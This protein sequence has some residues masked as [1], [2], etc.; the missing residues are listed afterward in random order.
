[1]AT[2][3]TFWSALR[4]LVAAPVP[5]PPQPIRPTRIRSLPAACTPGAV[6]EAP[7]SVPAASAAVEVLRK[8]R[9]EGAEEALKCLPLFIILFLQSVAAELY[10]NRREPVNR[11]K[12]TCIIIRIILK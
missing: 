12:N 10:S 2:S 7:T 9:R 5:R 4:A 1:M 6:A 3:L 8:S 11:Q